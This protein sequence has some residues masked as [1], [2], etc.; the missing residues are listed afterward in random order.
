MT[1]KLIRYTFFVVIASLLCV[2]VASATPLAKGTGW[3]YQV[4]Y[5]VPGNSFSTSYTAS[6]EETVLLT[7]WG[8]VS[9]QFNIF[10]DGVDVLSSSVVS[11]WDTLGLPGA[12]PSTDF[13]TF[14][15]VYASGLY[16]TAEFEV[17]KGDVI[18]IQLSHL[19]ANDPSYGN[20]FGGGT[21]GSVALEAVPEPVT[22]GFM[23]VSLLAL[24]SLS[25]RRRTLSK[26]QL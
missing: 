12:V 16:S 3:Q 2:S 9:D 1:S 26:E 7:A 6:I 15:Q 22:F 24:G 13:A 8:P 23:G 14:D 17:N 11:D 19:P 10:V 25:R 20:I 5:M 21:F 18:S 4:E